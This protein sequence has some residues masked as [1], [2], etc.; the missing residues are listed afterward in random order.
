MGR[1]DSRRAFLLQPSRAGAVAGTTMVTGALAHPKT[2]EAQDASHGHDRGEGHAPENSDKTFL[3][4]A[5]VAACSAR[6]RSSCATGIGRS[7]CQG[8]GTPARVE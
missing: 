2:A 5:L 3:V 4:P 8:A 6:D 7:R 1:P